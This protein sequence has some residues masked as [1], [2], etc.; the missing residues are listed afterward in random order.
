MEFA[1]VWFTVG[2]S[3]SDQTLKAYKENAKNAEVKSPEG[4]NGGVV[5]DKP[6][7]TTS[8]SAS[9]ASATKKSG[10]SVS[11]AVGA[12]NVALFAAVV[13]VLALL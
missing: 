6:S 4:V 13:G 3:G 2:R 9:S 7:S 1:N 10:A 5:R 8:S 12:S 11:G